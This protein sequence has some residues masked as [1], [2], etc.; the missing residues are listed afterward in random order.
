MFCWMSLILGFHNCILMFEFRL[1]I[2]GRNSTVA[3]IGSLWTPK[4]SFPNRYGCPDFALLPFSKLGSSQSWYCGCDVRGQCRPR[5]RLTCSSSTGEGI[6]ATCSGRS[7]WEREREQKESESSSNSGLLL[8][9]PLTW[10]DCWW[11]PNRIIQSRSRSDQIR[12]KRPN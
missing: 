4:I 10:A 1:C 6:M 3:N 2:S 11:I 9:W 8:T 7:P 5:H 12:K